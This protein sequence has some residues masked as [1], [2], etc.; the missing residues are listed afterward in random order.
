MDSFID[1]LG[2]WQNDNDHAKSLVLICFYAIQ[3]AI[4]LVW[5]L[6]YFGK[7]WWLFGVQNYLQIITFISRLS[8]LKYYSL[9]ELY[10]MNK[11]PIQKFPILDWWISYYKNNSKNV[12]NVLE[13]TAGTRTFLTINSHFVLGLELLPSLYS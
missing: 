10:F 7:H 2:N 8:F 12:H 13:I 6:K 11:T 9:I 1:S 5:F 4:V 3:L